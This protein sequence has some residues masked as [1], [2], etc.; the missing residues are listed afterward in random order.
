LTD[1]L[2]NDELA[3]ILAE[4]ERRAISYRDSSL[5]DD[6]EAALK[7]YEA[8]PF[9]DEEEGRSQIVVPVVQE[10]CD[11]MSIAVLRT[12][13]SGDRVVEFEAREEDQEDEAAEATE[14]VNLT[15]LRHQ[16]GY[17]VLHDWLKA[18]LVEK[19]CAV[20][21]ACIEEDKTERTPMEGVPEEYIGA[22]EE[23]T[24]GKIVQS[25]QNEDGTFSLVLERAKKV[26]KYVDIPIPN[27]ELLFGTRT[28]HEDEAH[29]IAHRSRKTASDLV[30]MGFD[31]KT[32]EDLPGNDE[33]MLDGREAER[34][35]DETL[36]DDDST[37]PGM[38]E[39]ILREE[40]RRV[41]MDGDGRAE[42]VKA[43][44]VGR[45]VLEWEEVDEN[46]FVVF[47][48][49][50][51]P[52]RM[53]GNSLA[54]KV[55]DL[56]R[57]RSVLL[58]QALD[59]TYMTN[60]PRM[61]VN[62]TMMGDNTIDDL[63][64]VIPGGIVRGKEK[65]EPLYNPF[66]PSKSMALMELLVGEQESR[67][68]ITRLNQ[69]LDADAL[70]KTATGTALMQAQGQQMEEFVARNFAEAF[71]R[72]LMKKLRLMIANGDPMMIKLDGKAKQVDPSRW[73]GDLDVSIRVGLGSGKKEQRLAYRQMVL[74]IQQAGHQ[75]GLVSD[76]Q[77]YN[78]GAGIVRD[79]ALGNP[80]DYF[81][82][83][84]SE[85]G[86]ALKAN[87]PQPPPDPAVQKV[88][89]DIQATEAKTQMQAMQMQ[90][91]HERKG[92]EL[93][94]SQDEAAAKIQ[95]MREEASAKLQLERERAAFEADLAQQQ[96]D[97]EFELA[98]QNAERDFM[99]RS[100]Q[101]ERDHELA[102]KKQDALPKN[103]PGGELDK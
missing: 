82:D 100:Q 12:M 79:S 38:R 27:E 13:V 66:D 61:F 42:L 69:G 30:E 40:Y 26:K 35:D 84:E 56:Q 62:E 80:L 94:Q 88:Q 5:A 75:M 55:M 45:T 39:Y 24:D 52:H 36:H 22:L 98:Q 32:V 97:R 91:D 48:P 11:Y 103:R 9:G 78:N 77:L 87:M 10:V 49:F 67:T 41:D 99:L 95:L 37:V 4:D 8:E 21:T 83:P 65:P 15:F 93:Q 101:A 34:W 90:A 59:G 43:F 102:I 68:G 14:A 2:T 60:A 1:R 89:S 6:Q 31:R 29:Y 50:P 71:S 47:C 28:R 18:G 17:K 51:R 64:T 85:E 74:E 53:V 19:I 57:V 7:F 96:A 23:A 73:S 58:R 63:L 3:I 76:K 46:P 72:L 44:R 70:N 25:T 33:S 20:K 92:M 16:D 54:D 81:T 86:K